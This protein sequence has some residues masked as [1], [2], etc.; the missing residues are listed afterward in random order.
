MA[1][2]KNFV[3]RNGIEV[4]QNLLVADSSTN[5][6]G[7]ATSTPKYTLEVR[8]GIGVTNFNAVGISTVNDLKING[9]IT[10][11]SSSGISGQYLISTGAGITWT[12]PVSN[13]RSIDRQTAGAGISTFST[14]YVIGLLDVY[15]NGVKLSDDEFTATD[16][17]TVVL[18]VACFGGETIEFVSY[19][20]ISNGFV[21][22]P[23]TYWT[24]SGTGIHTTSSVGIG[25]TN[26]TSKLTIRDGDI[27]VGISTAHGVI[28]TSP[29][30]TQ[31][32]LIVSD[33]G[34]L[35]TVTV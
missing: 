12:S 32:R 3:I 1:V 17:S 7:I 6:V 22:I 35:S 11:G 5:Q 13:V 8:G 27:S 4:N 2:Q 34:T 33:S 25:T 23:P 10:A 14:S 16:T 20:P 15:I 9:R 28:L 30:G 31:Y 24:T 18:D 26:P 21:T 29:N 19:S